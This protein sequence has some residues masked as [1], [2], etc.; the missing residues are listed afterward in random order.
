MKQHYMPN[1]LKAKNRM[2]IFELLRK[3]QISSRAELVRLTGISFPTILKI[4]DSLLEHRIIIELD[5]LEP[6]RGAGRR[7]HLLQFNPRAFYAIGISFEGQFASV[8]LVDLDGTCSHCRTMCIPQSDDRVALEAL[9][10]EIRELCAIAAGE[11]V[12]VLG[13]GI[14]FPAMINPQENTILSK[15]T[16]N[17]YSEIPFADA[18]P[19]FTSA[20]SLPYYVD[21]DVNLS[22]LGEF[23]LRRY[24]DSCRNLLYITLGTGCGS[25]LILDGAIWY[26]SS[27]VSG[28]L[29]NMRIPESPL[30]PEAPCVY[31]RL[32][33]LINLDAI[34]CRFGTDLS[35]NPPLSEKTRR[36]ITAYLC[37][38]FGCSLANLIYTL[39]MSHC[40]LSGIIPQALGPDLIRQLKAA[41]E[42]LLVSYQQQFLKIEPS[43]S[44]NTH[45][46]GA[47]ASVFNRQME[48]LFQN[49]P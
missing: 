22:C 14:G 41:T 10:P 49:I 21:N 44:P 42:P 19:E 34:R 23:F 20:L 5:Q 17:I 40:I 31:H 3:Q 39:D 35:L 6:R 9:L 45:I 47:A 36:D 32:E 2:M 7:G 12:P 18:F 8:G 28:E 38:Y 4:V 33:D 16:M 48:T 43:I 24:D 46:I 29:G 25:G 37:F 27:Y 13:I 11:Q 30:H 15:T 26:G 1:Y